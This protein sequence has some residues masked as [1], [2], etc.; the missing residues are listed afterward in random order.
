MQEYML[1]PS[2]E[3]LIHLFK[4]TGMVTSTL[5]QMGGPTLQT[6]RDVDASSHLHYLYS[7][8]ITYCTISEEYVYATDELNWQIAA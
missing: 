3:F 1:F 4:E 2:P 6:K 5:K 8:Y 7:T